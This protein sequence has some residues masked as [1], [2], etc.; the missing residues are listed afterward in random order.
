[1]YIDT[2]TYFLIFKCSL[3]PFEFDIK[4]HSLASIEAK[5]CESLLSKKGLNYVVSAKMSLRSVFP[6]RLVPLP[7]RR[8]ESAEPEIFS[9]GGK[10]I[11]SQI[12]LPSILGRL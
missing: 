11:S 1:M 10:G 12:P 3:V 6:L 7:N 8:Q 4:T 5:L 9:E 2:C